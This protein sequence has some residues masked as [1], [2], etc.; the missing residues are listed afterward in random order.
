MVMT[1][2]GFLYERVETLFV[3]AEHQLFLRTGQAQSPGGRRAYVHITPFDKTD[4]LSR[5]SLMVEAIPLHDGAR[6][7]ISTVDGNTVIHDGYTGTKSVFAPAAR[8][9]VAPPPKKTANNLK[10]RL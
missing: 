3:S 4:A 5:K 1:P 2:N 6:L 7:T 10:F 9:A 8:E